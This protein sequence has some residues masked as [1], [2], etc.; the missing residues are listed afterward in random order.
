PQTVERQQVQ[1]TVV[2]PQTV[3]RQQVQ[4]TVVKPQT[5]ERQQVQNI[6]PF[7]NVIEENFDE[8]SIF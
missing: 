1:N 2:K 6:D 7:A 4:N 5:V 8:L 3:E